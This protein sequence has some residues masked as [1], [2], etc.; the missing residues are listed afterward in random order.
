MKFRIKV[1][2]MVTGAGYNGYLEVFA[3]FNYKLRSAL[4]NAKRRKILG[5]IMGIKA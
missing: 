2:Y 1:H 4:E 3:D 5:M